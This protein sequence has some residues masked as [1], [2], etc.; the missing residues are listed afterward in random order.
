MTNS[1]RTKFRQ[2]P[3]LELGQFLT[4]L[5]TVPKNYETIM[6][7]YTGRVISRLAFGV[8]DHHGDIQMYSHGL[9]NAISPA[10]YITN[11]I[12]QL[13]SLPTWISPWKLTEKSRHATERLFFMRM[14][15]NVKESMENKSTAPSYMKEVLEHQSKTKLPDTEAAYIVGMVGL[16][17]V[18]TTSSSMMTYILAMTLYPH[19]QKKLQEEVDKVCGD[20]LPELSDSPSMPILRAVIMELIRWRPIVPSGEHVCRDKTFRDTNTYGRYSA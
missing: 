12:P 18:L 11:I 8:P 14:L 20:R 1:S 3:Y 4:E 5:I 16:A 6:E 7:N 15:D 17:S 10:A 9:L 2:V 19:W 13:K